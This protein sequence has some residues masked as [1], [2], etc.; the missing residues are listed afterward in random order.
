MQ[1]KY[2]LP[3]VQ[4]DYSSTQLLMFEKFVHLLLFEVFNILIS[5]DVFIHLYDGRIVAAAHVPFYLDV[6][7]RPVFTKAWLTFIRSS[8]SSDRFSPI[9]IFCCC[10]FGSFITLQPL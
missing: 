4:A 3:Y 5:K 8:S 6:K 10:K 7:T 9:Q 2:F 1:L